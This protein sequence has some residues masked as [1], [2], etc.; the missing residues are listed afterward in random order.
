[1]KKSLLTYGSS[2]ILS[3]FVSVPAIAQNAPEEVDE[4]G[5]P[6]IIVEAQRR[7]DNIQD[8]PLAVTAFNE[9]ILD[10]SA[11]E[12]IRDFAGRT[13]GL[14]VDN[15]G[16]GPSAAAIALRGI[17]F[18]DIEKSFDPAVGVSVDGV[19]IGTNTGQLL[20]AFD[21]EA[22]EILRG[23]QGTLFG[24]NTIAGVINLR[25]TAPTGELGVKASLSYAE[26]DTLRGRAVVNLP[27]IGDFLSLKGFFS[28]D[29]TDG[30]YFNATQ[31]RSAGENEIW[32]GGVTALIEPT[33]NI[34]ARITYEH[35]EQR[36]E[37][38]TTPVSNDG[39]AICLAAFVVGTP[40]AEC[41]RSTRSDDIFTVFHNI[42]T[43]LSYN[44]DSVTGEINIELGD[45]TLTSITG[46]QASDEDV[47]SDFD[48]SSIDFFD[49]RR[50]QDYEQFSQEV[51]LSGQLSDSFDF[52]LG[53]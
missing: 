45:L 38:V 11:V 51:R 49:T 22:I 29:R 32:S 39:D 44:A 27:K 16:A 28:Y 53:R 31:N 3:A 34:S 14:V 41:N 48:S 46:W 20:D 19:I 35:L 12:D 6:I 23:P 50:I 17:S 40:A 33:D 1:M 13:P 21:I 47:V 30:F 7:E 4:A 8:V 37:T 26:F 36:G 25:R 15:V 43:P 9:E 2:V 5:V 18:E 42:P 24:R 10:Q 52:V